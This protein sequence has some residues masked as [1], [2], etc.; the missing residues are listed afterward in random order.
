MGAA[1]T[2]P[3]FKD[4][5]E[6]FMNSSNILTVPYQNVTAA[7]RVPVAIN[8][9]AINGF[10]W[11]QPYPGSRIDGH[12]ANLQVAQEM[13]LSA[14]LVEN[15]TTV[16]SSLTFGIPD[17]MTSRG[18]P[19]AMDPSWYICRHVFISTKPDA[20]QAV[21]GGSKCGFLSQ[22]CRADLKTSLTQDWGQAA[23]GTMCSALGFD[24]IPR[25]CQASFGLAR[26]DVMAFDAAFVANTTLGPAQTSKEQQLYSW[27]I[28]TGYHDPGDARAYA[29]AANRTYLVATVWGYSQSAKSIKVPEV[30]FGCLSSGASYVPPPPAPSS[31]SPTSTA[32]STAAS[33]TASTFTSV[34]SP[35]AIRNKAAFGDDM[36]KAKVNIRDGIYTSG[37]TVMRAFNKGAIFGNIQI[38]TLAFRDDF[39]SDTMG[40]WTIIDGKY[41]VSSNAVVLSASPI[42]KALTTGLISKDLVYE[43]DIFIDSASGNGDGGFIFRV[44]NAK[45]GPDSY[46]GYYAGIGNGLV[47]LGR[48]DSNWNRLKTV[49]AADIKA[50]QK[51]HLMIRARGDS[52]SVYVDD[53]NT[54]RMVVKDGKYATGLSGIRAYMTT[55]SMQ[56]V[57]D[58]DKQLD[59]SFIWI[60]QLLYTSQSTVLAGRLLTHS[61]PSSFLWLISNI[62]LPLLFMTVFLAAGVTAN[63]AAAKYQALFF[64]QLYRLEVDAHGLANSRMAPGC[65]KA[66][67]VCDLEAFIKEVCTVKKKPKRDASGNI[68]RLPNGKPELLM[69]PDLAKIVWAHV[70]EGAD[71]DVFSTEFDKSGFSGN[72]DNTKIFKGW[73]QKDTFE[74]VMTEAADIGTKAIAKLKA[75][76]REPADDRV[77]KMIAALKTHGDARRY[78]QARMIT[79][80]FQN[81]MNKR[82][83]TAALTAPIERPPV[84]GYRKIDAVQTISDNAGRAGFQ[85]IES[86]VRDYVTNFNSAG[87]S[88]SHVDAIVKTQDVHNHFAQVCQT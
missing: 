24:A 46:N 27:R 71:L 88:K 12:T 14:S 74:T 75:E 69:E 19:L 21:D 44:S 47:V 3:V 5:G 61:G 9:T 53:L 17:S 1:L 25:S 83:F 40:K 8:S 43:A 51:H 20:K 48:A 60:L 11:T 58:E 73:N 35:T 68:I 76:G 31:S 36:S 37:M 81:E 66:G 45:A 78:D 70:G 32:V 41:Q 49:Q 59:P 57:Q 67:G 50:G 63:K 72:F 38:S 39:S 23:D 29:L 85:K 80:A 82:R 56:R 2:S 4:Y 86:D 65:V 18:H 33:T 7:F 87:L 79:T 64:Y 42:A 62:M 26:Q 13:A 34:P 52:I 6:F 16:L 28:G 84:P 15:A 10:D 54:P 30:S 77:N 55:L 22:S